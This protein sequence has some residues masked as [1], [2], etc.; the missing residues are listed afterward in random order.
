VQVHA[1]SPTERHTERDVETKRERERE[2]DTHRARHREGQREP[3]GHVVIRFCGLP[4]SQI[5]ECQQSAD[6]GSRSRFG[7]GA[8]KLAEAWRSWMR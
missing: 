7:E 1:V 8:R 6:L 4:I 3:G 2:R 5:P